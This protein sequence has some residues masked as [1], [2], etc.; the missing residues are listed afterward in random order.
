[1]LLTLLA[2]IFVPIVAPIAERYL[3]GRDDPS[4]NSVVGEKP[5]NFVPQVKRA[6][7][8]PW[9][10]EV[11]MPNEGGEVSFGLRIENTGR[12][13][14]T[15]LSV[16]MALPGIFSLV[17]GKCHYKVDKN[18]GVG[19]SS[20]II[21]DGVVLPELGPGDWVH[22]VCTADI[23]D[24]ATGGSYAATLKMISDQTEE[25]IKSVSVHLP[26]S[27]D[28]KTVHRLFATAEGETEFWG[29]APEIAY[30]SESVLLRHWPEFTL[31]RA[32]SYNAVPNGKL[33]TLEDLAF[34][35]TLEGR[36]VVSQGRVMS[37]PREYPAGQGMVKESL[38][39]GL[40]GTAPRLFCYTTRPKGI[41]LEKG[42]ELE[43]KAV[44]IA[45]GPQASPGSNEWTMG[46]CPGARVTRARSEVPSRPAR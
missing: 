21:D 43:V 16:R 13:A 44:V 41:L 10:G 4:V 20:S 11:A 2:T 15:G 37:R 5:V 3:L 38:E 30:A 27:S 33:V 7:P 6:G 24:A 28:E 39:L 45:W 40:P 23:S 1:M 46:V 34:D 42:D 26:T 18:A 36:V 35:H 17:P 31:E 25:E 8:N 9:S 32:H 19:C 29:G 12:Q 22:V 14:I